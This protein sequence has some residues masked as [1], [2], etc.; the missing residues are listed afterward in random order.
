MNITAVRLDII[1][2]SQGRREVFGLG[3]L[4]LASPNIYS[5]TIKTLALAFYLAI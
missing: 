2:K 4:A 5:Y 3:E 1:A